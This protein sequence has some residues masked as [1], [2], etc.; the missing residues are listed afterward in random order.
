MPQKCILIF[1]AWRS[2]VQ[3]FTETKSL[4]FVV[5]DARAK[6]KNAVQ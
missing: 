5:F 2:V 4:V 1:A 6:K 3:F